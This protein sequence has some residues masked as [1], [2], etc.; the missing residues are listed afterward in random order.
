MKAPKIVVIC[1]AVL[2]GALSA[3][4]QDAFDWRGTVAPG[5]TVNVN[6][7][8]GEVRARPSEDGFVHVEATQ[9]A[10]AQSVS[11]RIVVDEHDS[12]ITVCPVYVTP[13]SPAP[14]SC[15]SNDRPR[16][17]RGEDIR[18]DFDIRVPQGVRLNVATVNGDIVAQQLR[19]DVQATTVNGRVNIQTMGFVSRVTTVNG[20]VELEVPAG[21]DADFH[22][23]TVHGAIEADFPLTRSQPP[24]FGN[25]RRGGNGPQTARGTIGN[26]GQELR[27][28]T[29]NGS[30]NVRR[31]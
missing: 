26:G 12:G 1:T 11:V 24:A 17:V 4:A 10:A 16:N 8:N 15:R 30:I 25:S 21:M 7:I 9:P 14:T 18:V 27:V 28:T 20:D 19:S 23:N 29:V 6:N 2:A 13:D 3:A 22:A 5:K 31:R